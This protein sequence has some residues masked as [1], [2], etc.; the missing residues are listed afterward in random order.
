[1][2]ARRPGM[3]FFSD[4]ISDGF[5]CPLSSAPSSPSLA[6]HLAPLQIF[7]AFPNP[8][9]FPQP[10]GTMRSFRGVNFGTL[11]SSPKETE[12]LLPDLKVGTLFDC[13]HTWLTKLSCFVF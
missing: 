12:E 9:P 4:R 13:G 7:S 2:G 10:S 8:S 11:L 6:L 1:M 5:L 3:G